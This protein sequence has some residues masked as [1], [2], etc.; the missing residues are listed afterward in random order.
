MRFVADNGGGKVF[1]DETFGEARCVFSLPMDMRIRNLLVLFVF[2]AG[3]QAQ[4]ETHFVVLSSSAAKNINAVQTTWSPTKVDIDDAEAN[5]S[6]VAILKAEGWS[7]MIQID[8]PERYFRQYVPVR[9]AGKRVLYLN[10]F[11]DENTPAYWRKRLV[12]VTDGGTCYW[13]A[14]YDPATKKYS[15][16]TIN[17]RA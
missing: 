11:C 9:R 14:F 6:Q 17:G 5:I 2:V 15:H 1:E 16:L 4:Q 3:A 12:I 7:S 8:H 10:A 13:Q